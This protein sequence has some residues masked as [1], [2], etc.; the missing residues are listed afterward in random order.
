[1]RARYLRQQQKD[2]AR[3]ERAVKRGRMH[4]QRQVERIAHL[5]RI[6]GDTA[7]AQ[8]VLQTFHQT[9]RLHEE[10]LARIQ[11]EIKEDE[12]R[13]SAPR[14]GPLPTAPAKTP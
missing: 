11:S 7:Q 8:T 3:A 12:K 13:L 2:L 1:M 6:R 5:E 9:H 10:D 14:A 4:I